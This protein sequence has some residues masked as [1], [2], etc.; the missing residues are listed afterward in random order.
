MKTE[1]LSRNDKKRVSV[2]YFMSAVCIGIGLLMIGKNTGY[3]DEKVYH[4]LLSWPMLFILWSIKL[5]IDR[6]FLGG[7]IFAVI[8]L[9]FILPKWGCVDYNLNHQV[10]WPT[11]FIAVG[12]VLLFTAKKS[13]KK[14]K[15]RRD[16]SSNIYDSSDGYVRSENV[17]G[18]VQ[19]IVMDEAFMGATIK[20]SFGGTILDLRRTVL[21]AEEVYVD[22]DCNFGGIEIYAPSHWN[23]RM[24]VHPFVGGCDDS[25]L[26]VNN[27]DTARTLVI[28]GKVSFGGLEIKG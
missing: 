9:Y 21:A 7:G 15:R 23:I 6:N 14:W 19:R 12:L 24:E 27:I 17:F 4:A 25:R 2:R 16:S 18:S 26:M 22:V 11:F 28:R 13:V 8:G 3:I 1:E 10:V 5:F 20:N